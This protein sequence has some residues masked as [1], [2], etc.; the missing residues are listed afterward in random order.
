MKE[1]KKKHVGRIIM[2]ALILFLVWGL[3]GNFWGP[4]GK[5]A[6]WRFNP[7]T[8][9]LTITGSGEMR[10]YNNVAFG[11]PRTLAPALGRFSFS[12]WHLKSTLNGVPWIHS[13]SD[14]YKVVIKQG[15]TSV[16][17][18]SFADC[19]HLKHVSM[20]KTVESI[21]EYAFSGCK[22]LK[23][24]QI[25]SSVKFIGLHAVIDTGL[26]TLYVPKQTYIEHEEV[27]SDP[28]L[29][30]GTIKIIRR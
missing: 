25:P 27:Y 10:N 21:R 8:H 3:S 5:S 6:Y 1:K 7:F 9:T 22:N 16:G 20:P 11:G 24:L 4:C 26:H 14:I 19:D 28:A 12:L 13:G 17:S 30:M 29:G 15:I 2:I 23:V 18:G